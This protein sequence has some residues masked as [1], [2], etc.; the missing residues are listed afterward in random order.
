MWYNVNSLEIK[1]VVYE[2][3]LFFKDIKICLGLLIAAREMHAL[4]RKITD[5]RCQQLQKIK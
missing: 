5:S 4:F 3:V 2:N 1:V